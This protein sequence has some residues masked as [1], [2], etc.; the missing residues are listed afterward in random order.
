MLRAIVGRELRQAWRGGA[1]IL[2]PLWFFLVVITLFPLAIGAEP[3]LLRRLAPGIIWVAAVLAALLMMDRLFRDD[4]QDGSLQQLL[5]LPVPLSWVVIAKVLAHWL[6]TGLPLLLIA[7]L[8]ALLLGMSLPH[9]LILLATLLCGTPIL[10][11]LGAVGAGLTVGVRR[12]GMLLSLLILP[13]TV[14]LLIF[15][16][17]AVDAFASHQSVGGYFA[18]LGAMLI[19]CATLCPFATAAALRLSVQSV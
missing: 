10:S 11:F 1:E 2:N 4:Q 15:A 5:L 6:V 8:A 3:A 12:G 7:P 18:L 16:I 17:G 13:L 9:T 19:A 14:P